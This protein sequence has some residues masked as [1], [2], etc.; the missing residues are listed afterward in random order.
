MFSFLT[1][2]YSISFCYCPGQ[3]ECNCRDFFY[4]SL[5][6]FFLPLSHVFVS[7]CIYPREIHFLASMVFLYLIRFLQSSFS[8]LQLCLLVQTAHIIQSITHPLCI[9]SIWL[10][11]GFTR[12]VCLLTKTSF[13]LWKFHSTSPKF[14]VLKITF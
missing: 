5:S 10:V 12:L 13:S 1:F 11:R 3:S 4:F 14:N 2:L 8:S 7:S 9:C 6:F